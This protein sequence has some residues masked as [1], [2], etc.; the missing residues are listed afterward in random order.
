ML[1]VSVHGNAQ[2]GDASA[3]VVVAF[4]RIIIEVGGCIE[5][6]RNVFPECYRREWNAECCSR[7]WL[8]R[9]L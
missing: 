2:R 6:M 3:G 8:G 4:H 1:R 7:V 9:T 5:L